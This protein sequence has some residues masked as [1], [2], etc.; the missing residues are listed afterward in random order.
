M[1][2]ERFNDHYS[3]ARQFYVSQTDV[4]KK[5]IADALVFELS[6]VERVEIRE[7]MVA[8]LLNIDQDLANQVATGLRLPEMPQAAEAARAPKMDLEPS[9]ALSIAKNGPKSFAGRCVGI[10][11]TDGVDAA[12]LKA[13]MDALTKEGASAKLIAPQVGGVK[14]SDGKM[15]RANEKID[16]GPSVLFDAVALMV[17]EDGA[18]M[19]ADVP[20]ARDFIADA[21]AHGKF[22]AHIPLQLNRCWIK[23]VRRIS[24]NRSWSHWTITT[25]ARSSN[26]AEA[27]ATGM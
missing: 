21:L 20:A 18:K 3:Q 13:L 5:H 17:T 12:Q 9:P 4:E 16:G 1:R 19:L 22:I 23:L 6:K 2:S 7:A 25:P 15:Y 10:L 24:T 8:H 27:F 26:A 11:V 14:A